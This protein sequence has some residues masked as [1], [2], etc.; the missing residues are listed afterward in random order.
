LGATADDVEMTVGDGIKTA[1]VDC[2]LQHNLPA[3]DRDDNFQ[4]AIL[5][6]FLFRMASG[7]RSK[8]VIRLRAKAS[9]LARRIVD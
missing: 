2:D 7:Q 6:S 9:R 8:R 4:G 5:Q 3:L 1:R